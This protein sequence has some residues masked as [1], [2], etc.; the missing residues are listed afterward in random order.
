MG[1][2]LPFTISAFRH[3]YAKDGPEARLTIR[4]VNNFRDICKEGMELKATETRNSGFGSGDQ[5]VYG[6]EAE[7]VTLMTIRKKYKYIALMSDGHC[8]SWTELARLNLGLEK[9]SA[10]A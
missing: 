2:T 5:V 10:P 1:R 8:Q 9:R 4:E 7:K 3:F 6:N